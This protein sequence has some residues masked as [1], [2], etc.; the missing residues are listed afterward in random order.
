MSIELDWKRDDPIPK[1]PEFIMSERFLL[2]S[3]KSGGKDILSDRRGIIPRIKSLKLKIW[4]FPKVVRELRKRGATGET[5]AQAQIPIATA[6][7][8]IF[9]KK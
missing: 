5:N 7:I 1:F 9:S 8:Y 2:E 4:Y 6:N 3:R